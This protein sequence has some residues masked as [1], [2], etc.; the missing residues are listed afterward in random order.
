VLAV[1]E[2]G[3]HD[4]HQLV[5]NMH[6]ATLAFSE[7]KEATEPLLKL[8][9]KQHNAKAD[10]YINSPTTNFVT[11]ALVVAALCWWNP[12]GWGVGA[13]AAAGV[14]GGGTASTVAAGT[15]HD[16]RSKARAKSANVSKGKS[17]W[18]VIR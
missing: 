2:L 11:V 13:V 16:R 9:A 1:I 17:T 18:A 14:V 3:N 10:S 15:A 5:H 8:L 6:A 12:L 4:L 7:V